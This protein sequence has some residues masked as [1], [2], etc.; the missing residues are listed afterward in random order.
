MKCYQCKRYTNEYKNT[1]LY[2]MS[3]NNFKEVPFC[4]NCVAIESYKEFYKVKQIKL[5]SVYIAKE[6]FQVQIKVIMNGVKY[7]HILLEESL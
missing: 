2:I 4:N 5:W 6:W 7:F 3:N 1:L